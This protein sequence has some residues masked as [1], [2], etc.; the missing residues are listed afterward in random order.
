MSATIHWITSR[1]LIVYR[2][3]ISCLAIEKLKIF[4]LY[5][6]NPG[7][8]RYEMTKSSLRTE[9]YIIF[10]HYGMIVISQMCIKLSFNELAKF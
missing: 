8:C 10:V 1:M 2:I 9:L 6:F 3:L 4:L 7:M 5:Y